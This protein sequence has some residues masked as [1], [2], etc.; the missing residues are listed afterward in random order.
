MRDRAGVV[1]RWVL[2]LGKPVGALKLL[3]SSG[4]QSGSGRCKWRALNGPVGTL[5][6]RTSMQ[7]RDKDDRGG[8]VGRST[9]R[10][11]NEAALVCKG[12]QLVAVLTFSTLSFPS[13]PLPEDASTSTGPLLI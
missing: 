8:G 3:G 5:I 13:S 12:L 2:S 6:N 4:A 9:R 7:K 10:T 1:S 11:A